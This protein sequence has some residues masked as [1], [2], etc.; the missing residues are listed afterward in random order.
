MMQSKASKAQAAA[1]CVLGLS[2]IFKPGCSRRRAGTNGTLASI[3]LHMACHQLLTGSASSRCTCIAPVAVCKQLRTDLALSCKGIPARQDA[4]HCAAAA[5]WAHCW[6]DCR[7]SWGK[8]RSS[9]VRSSRK[10][11]GWSCR[12]SGSRKV[13]AHRLS[14][15]RHFL[16]EFLLVESQMP[17][18]EAIICQCCF[19]GLCCMTSNEQARQ[20]AVPDCHGIQQPSRLLR[21]WVLAQALRMPT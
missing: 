8:R 15:S 14:C 10:S 16:R 6:M 13:C 17:G 1:G 19:Q 3:F 4:M 21:C 18:D 9:S 20:R 11:C 7:K 5:A 12:Y 2:S